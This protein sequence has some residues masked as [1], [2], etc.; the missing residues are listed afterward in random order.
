MDRRRVVTFIGATV[1]LTLAWMSASRA[2]SEATPIVVGDTPGLGLPGEDCPISW[3]PSILA[4]VFYGFEDY[5]LA[6]GAPDRL[7]IYFP[8]LSGTP[9]SGEILEDCGLYPLVL[10]IHGQTSDPQHFLAWDY[11]LSEL[12]ESGYVVVAAQMG[13]GTG[14]DIEGD[15]HVDLAVD[16]LSWMRESWEHRGQIMPGATG[17][18]GHSRGALVGGR[19]ASDRPDLVSAFVSLSGVWWQLLGIDDVLSAITA[20]SLFQR[21]N[22][23][24]LDAMETAAIAD[25]LSAAVTPNIYA[26]H[27]ITFRGGAH[28]DYLEP[29]QVPPADLLGEQGDC[30]GMMFTSQNFVQTFLGRYLPPQYWYQLPSLI[31]IDLVPPPVNQTVEQVFYANTLFPG[32]LPNVSCPLTDKWVVGAAM[33]EITLT[34]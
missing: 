13:G 10:F 1:I 30:G 6:D 14:L 18:I 29:D 7:R 17:V 25:Y 11:F 8:S 21:G 34:P 9:Q 4:P 16:I 19:L 15:Q 3:Q 5:G 33:G 27:S 32:L 28:W 23:G 12:A 20:P 2:Q 31:P 26:K 24:T 22:S